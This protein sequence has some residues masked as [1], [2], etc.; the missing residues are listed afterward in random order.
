MTGPI[1]NKPIYM[2]TKPIRGLAD[3]VS[4]D[5]AANKGQ[6]DAAITAE[7]LLNRQIYS[8]SFLKAGRM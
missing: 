2:G 1:R 7:M 6:M 3:G 4:A 5:D 8:E